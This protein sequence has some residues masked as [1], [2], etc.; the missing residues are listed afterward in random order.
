MKKFWFLCSLLLVAAIGVACEPVDDT[1]TRL[2]FPHDAVTGPQVNGFDEDN[3]PACRPS[4]PTGT[5]TITVTGTYGECEHNG[6][7]VVSST[8]A[9][10]TIAN[11]VV[12]AQSGGSPLIT[13][14]SSDLTVTHSIM[15]APPAPWSNIGPQGQP[16]GAGIAYGNY[17]LHYSEVYG[18]ADSVKLANTV[19]VTNSFFHDNFDGC[20][21]V[22]TTEC[23]HTDIAQKNDNTLPHTISVTW[24]H[25]ASYGNSCDSNRHFQMP[26]L[27]DSTINITDSFFYGLHGILNID[28]TATST[29]TGTI[30]DNVLAGTPSAGPFTD[31]NLLWTG[32]GLGALTFSNNT[33]ED[34]S[35]VHSPGG[36]VPS[37][38]TCQATPDPNP[39]TTTTTTTTT[40]TP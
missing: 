30:G 29:N 40:T 9:G 3:L 37:P 26:H 19:E 34:G 22:N 2:D 38:Y 33:Y 11:M 27:V 14:E 31:L 4:N 5:W 32:G 21:P 6:R 7:I 1:T 17:E 16:C 23:S 10:T 36:T 28:K 13:N 15:H 25:N 8:A 35:P 24:T 18:C 12:E 39:V 20:H